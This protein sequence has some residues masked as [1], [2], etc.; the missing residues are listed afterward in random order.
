MKITKF[1]PNNCKLVRRRVEEALASVAAEFGV[2]IH[3]RGGTYTD[4]NYTLKVEIATKS[5]TGEVNTREA[6][7]FRRYAG[8][9][10][11]KPSDLFRKVTKSG[12][13]VVQ[14]IGLRPRAPKWPV[15]I[16]TGEGKRLCMR[17]EDAAKLLA[18]ADGAPA[19]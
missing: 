15:I 13:E 7:D 8:A 17:A 9:Y 10:G 1:E 4:G 14:I 12:G 2:E 16:E 6:D 3:A 18:R 19:P 11:L 5:E